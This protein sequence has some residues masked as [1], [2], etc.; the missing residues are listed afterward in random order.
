MAVQ[1]S[2]C[3]DKKKQ[4][5][6]WLDIYL[7]S[8]SLIVTWRSYVQCGNYKSRIIHYN[9]QTIRIHVSLDS[10]L[11]NMTDICRVRPIHVKKKDKI[12]HTLRIDVCVVRRK[13]YMT[14]IRRVWSVYAETET[15]TT[16]EID[17][18]MFTWHV[19]CHFGPKCIRKRKDD[20]KTNHVRR[21]LLHIGKAYTSRVNL[22]LRHA[23]DCLED[24]RAFKCLCKYVTWTIRIEL[25]S[26]T[27]KQKLCVWMSRQIH[28][29]P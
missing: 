24:I 5:I 10:K 17:G 23:Q 22:K 21:F 18:W 20:R 4:K 29:Q 8:L 9:K 15:C 13:G 27:Q 2:K 26:R 14:H 7:I 3:L 11:C 12:L 25:R 19:I 16:H 6:V 1:T 28:E